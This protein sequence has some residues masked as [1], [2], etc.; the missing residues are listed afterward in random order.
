LQQGL[1]LRAE[2]SA[3][4]QFWTFTMSNSKALVGYASRTFN[5]VRENLESL[6]P[7]PQAR[8]IVRAHGR[9][10]VMRPPSLPL[11]RA[12]RS[13]RRG[14]KRK[15]GVIR[16]WSDND[17]AHANDWR[18]QRVMREGQRQIGSLTCGVGAGHCGSLLPVGGGFSARRRLIRFSRIASGLRLM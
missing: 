6:R 5:R 9:A 10:R 17:R 18:P 4:G 3:A 12:R 13:V 15:D 2:R 7:L 11:R 14:A 16:W 1:P 8:S